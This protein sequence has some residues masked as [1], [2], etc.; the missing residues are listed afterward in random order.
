MII[1]T[2]E[3]SQKT[4]KAS[5]LMMAW[6]LV[7]VLFGLLNIQ[8]ALA[9]GSQSEKLQEYIDRNAEL[10]EWSHDIVRETEN[11][12]A[13]KV[14]EEA[15]NLHRRS[16][17]LMEDGRFL[18]SYNTAKHCRTAMRNAVR[19]ARESM[20]FEERVR[21]RSERFRDQH[22][23]LLEKARE[24]HNEQALSFLQRSEN[25][26]VRAY[27]Q[28]QQG[29]ARLAFKMLEQAEELLHRAGR[30]LSS[31]GNGFERLERTIEMARLAQDR[32]R[33]KLQNSTDSAALKLMTESDEALDRALDFKDQG[34]PERA[35]QMAGLAHRLANRVADGNFSGP[36]D[37][38]VLRQ[39]ERWDDR[40][41]GV[42][43][44]IREARNETANR[45][46]ERAREQR[47]SASESLDQDEVE[48]ALRRIRAAHDLLTRA[49]DMVK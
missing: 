43:E 13:R 36:S 17:R 25:M 39:I 27:E 31:G 20:G 3:R 32:A 40:S 30:M 6:G 34:Q 14:L 9:Q 2:Q 48:T 11:M 26:A 12:P 23:H 41:D 5:S 24:A 28:Y 38:A 49:E 4:I 18:M 37:E 15:L 7:F 1:P 35:L 46:F 45:L 47:K 42:L 8:P 16:I 22:A 33:E 19:M 10:L 29:D 21:L 44:F